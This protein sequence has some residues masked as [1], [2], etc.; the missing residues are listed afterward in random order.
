MGLTTAQTATLGLSSALGYDILA[1]EFLD[2]PIGLTTTVGIQTGIWDSI[3]AG[4]TQYTVQLEDVNKLPAFAVGD[5]VK[6][7]NHSVSPSLASVEFIIAEKITVD[8]SN[9]RLRLTNPVVWNPATDDYVSGWN[10]TG[11]GTT[12]S[13]QNG[14]AA[15]GDYITIRDR[16]TIAKGRVGVI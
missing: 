10:A 11:A 15:A 5:I 6:L 12:T 16:F 9:K 2:Y 3:G 1:Q 8:A 7:V 4:Q 14:V 13:I